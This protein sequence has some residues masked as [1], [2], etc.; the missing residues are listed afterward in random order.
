MRT[1]SPPLGTT[2]AQPAERAAQPLGLHHP[3]PHIVI[4]TGHTALVEV[5]QQADAVALI[6]RGLRPLPAVPAPAVALPA[7]RGEEAHCDRAH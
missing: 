5:E 4:P 7:A 3:Q 2:T 1:L 6:F